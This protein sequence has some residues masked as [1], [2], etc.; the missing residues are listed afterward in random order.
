MPR[1]PRF[2]DLLDDAA[3]LSF[4]HRVYLGEVLGEHSWRVN[5][6]AGVFAF[7]TERGA[8]ECPRFHFLGSAA[9]GAGTWMWAWANPSGFPPA[10]SKL[11]ETVRD[12]GIAHRIAELATAEL[13]FDAFPGPRPLQVATAQTE[14]AKAVTGRWTSYLGAGA[15]GT[16]VAFLV[17]HPAFR[18]PAPDPTRVM[19]TLTQGLTTLSLRDHRRAI[20]RYLV[21]RGMNW[22]F[23][24][25][26]TL[27]TV[28]SP[29]L[30]GTITFDARGRAEALD[31]NVPART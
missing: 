24:P 30:T 5:M 4:E 27:L 21:L 26:Y 12:F 20:T 19:R 22:T 2:P 18:L 3:L 9:V 14:A 29:T 25:D 13:P 17:E 6:R 23:T 7:D 16:T 28:D 8:I 11:S 31:L 1:S 10:V 15:D